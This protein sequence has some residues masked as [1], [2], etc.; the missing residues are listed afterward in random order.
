MEIESL[1]RLADE[2]AKVREYAYACGEP[3][4]VS[5]EVADRWEWQLRQMTVPDD[6]RPVD[7]RDPSRVWPGVDQVLLTCWM[8]GSDYRD[9]DLIGARRSLIAALS[10]TPPTARPEVELCNV[11]SGIGY[12]LTDQR[13]SEA[14]RCLNC[15]GTG[16]MRSAGDEIDVM[17]S[18]VSSAGDVDAER[19][20]RC[21]DGCPPMT[22]CDW[23]QGVES[24]AQTK[25]ACTVAAD[26]C[27]VCEQAKAE[28]DAEDSE[29]HAMVRKLRHMSDTIV[30]HSPES[31]A[32]ALNDAANCVSILFRVSNALR[33]GLKEA[34]EPK[35]AGCEVAEN[36]ALELKL[37]ADYRP[38]DASQMFAQPQAVAVDEAMAHRALAACVASRGTY[39]G[40]VPL[41]IEDMRAAILAALAPGG[42]G[43][44]K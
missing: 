18:H 29:R 43:N 30:E 9:L 32:A 8:Q 7:A 40:E 38:R 41:D 2:I 19:P 14:V 22:V 25:H 26:E 24:D 28:G 10:T 5:A 23:C 16:T 21:A 34:T 27:D 4:Y 39:E 12:L 42:G 15:D 37:P 11:C 3:F 17:E 31:V 6:G 20:Q 1:R 36:H 35:P 13:P 33:A 44:T